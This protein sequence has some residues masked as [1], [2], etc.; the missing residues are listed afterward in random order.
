MADPERPNIL[1]LTVEDMS[2]NL[3]CYGDDYATTPNLDNF[4]KESVRYTRAFATAP[5]C[6][7]SRSTLITGCYATSLGTQR[8]RS[9]RSAP[10]MS[11]SFSPRKARASS[12]GAARSCPVSRA[13]ARSGCRAILTTS[14]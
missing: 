6:S 7:P 8:L 4:A 10:P 9:E 12:S 2:A 14:K 1:W 13:S 5:C 3:G 11:S